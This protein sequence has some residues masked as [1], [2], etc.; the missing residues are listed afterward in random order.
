MQQKHCGEADDSS[1]AQKL[2]RLLAPSTGGASEP[3]P[4]DFEESGTLSF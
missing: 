3:E 2:S 4:V 1:Q